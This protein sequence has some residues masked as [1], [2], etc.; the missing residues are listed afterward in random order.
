VPRLLAAL[1][2]VIPFVLLTGPAAGQGSPAANAAAA[3]AIALSRLE[4][5]GD[6]NAL[7]DRIHPDAHAVIP[8]AA[9]VGWFEDQFAPRGPGVASVTDVQFGPWTWPVTG[10]TYPNTATVTFQQPF[11][12]GTVAEDVVRLVQDDSGEW[13]WFFGRDRAFVDA[14]IARY[15][16]P[17]PRFIG[18]GGSVEVVVEDL[19]TFWQ[20]AF[21]AGGRT[22]PTPG[23]V[24][25]D[26]PLSTACGEATPEELPAAYCRL[27]ATIYYATWFFTE[28]ETRFGDYSWV[29]I[30][31]H[32]WGHH[33]QN[34]LGIVPQASN[35]FELQAD[36]LAGAYA[37]DAGTRGLLDPGEVTEAVMT[38]AAAG[39]DPMWPQDRPGAHGTND[40]RIASFMRGYLDGFLGCQLAIT[41]GGSAQAQPELPAPRIPQQEIA[42]ELTQLLPTVSEVPPGLVITE[43]IERSLAQVVAN[44]NNPAEAE[45]LFT[46]WGWTENVARTFSLANGVNPLPGATVSVYVSLHRFASGVA[47]TEALNYSFEDQATT[48]GTFEIESRLLGDYTRALSSGD[49]N[50][51]TIYAQRGRVLLRLTVTMFEGSPMGHAAAIADAILREANP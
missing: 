42:Q 22:Y 50:E 32:E 38:S 13:R 10:E 16:P 2:A 29:N 14:Q 37:R 9:A 44:Y 25:L 27:D 31:A 36:C 39:D 35:A 17:L 43:D 1:L 8:R 5:A 48:P 12:D 45:R 33:I 26:G 28:Q 18:N 4:A 41:P 46:T 3:T 21:D 19:D 40:N 24:R 47:G 30:L 6:F 15:V 7:Y 49:G 51:V 34:A 23:V 20:I 11:A